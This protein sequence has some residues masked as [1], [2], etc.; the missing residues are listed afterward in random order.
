MTKICEL[1][2]VRQTQET[3][4][5]RGG[6]WVVEIMSPVSGWIIQGVH[7]TK[8]AADEDRKNWM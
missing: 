6:F 8:T 2:R 3:A 5:E 1:T 7:R 4:T